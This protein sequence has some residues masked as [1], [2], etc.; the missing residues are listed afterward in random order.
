MS[1][2]FQ[3]NFWEN[4]GFEELRKYM[5][6]GQD[7]CRDVAGI[8][9]E[10]AEVELEYAKSMARV[11]GKALRIQRNQL[12]TLKT[13]WDT[14]V[15]RMNAEG[16]AHRKLGQDMINDLSKPLKLFADNQTKARKPIEAPVDKATK[17]LS[18]KR[19]DELRSKRS[20]H[21]KA[22]ERELAIEQ[23]EEAK[24]VR[25]PDKEVQKV[26]VK[27]EKAT[28][29]AAKQDHEYLDMCRKAEEARQSWETAMY[30]C[31]QRFQGMET[32]RCI[33]MREVFTKYSGMLASVAPLFQESC[34]GINRDTS[35][36]NPAYDISDASQKFGTAK[37]TPDQVLYTCYEDDLNSNMNANRR[38]G[39]LSQ[40]LG[41]LQKLVK[42]ARKVQEGIANLSSV[43]KETPQ[44]ATDEAQNDVYRQLASANAMID[45]Y[46]GC[47]YRLLCAFNELEGQPKSEHR[48]STFL[49]S[50]R[51]KQNVVHALLRVS[52]GKG[53][54]RDVPAT[55][56]DAD[57]LSALS[58]SSSAP[59]SQD[60]AAPAAKTGKP[61]ARPSSSPARP[62]HHTV[63]P[64][65]N[66]QQQPADVGHSDQ[67]SADEFDDDDDDFDDYGGQE[68][69]ATI[70]VPSDEIQFICQCEALY[71]YTANESDELT[72]APGDVINVISKQEDGWW[73]GELNGSVGIFPATYVTVLL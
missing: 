19:N 5:K 45:Y 73:Q 68:T 34:E 6:S 3:D 65:V 53:G 12:G 44:Y 57:V 59:P 61:P 21:A 1:L 35:V 51:D 40:R 69:E 54:M 32:E 47:R 72:I 24:N 28:E 39:A 22:R 36:I 56:D 41:E 60:K 2:E 13:A 66:A 11:V 63:P 23:L 67:H 42:Q 55:D 15:A 8:L 46:D 37:N 10:R 20:N 71:D 48:L 16:E 17:T 33:H 7:F 49:S 43:Y 14:V 27:V 64:V 52:V 31:C 62:P 58:Q 26:E 18:D 38:R 30:N 70:G 50:T 9:H 4:G 25:K 29:V